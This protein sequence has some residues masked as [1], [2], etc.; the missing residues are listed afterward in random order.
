MS[1]T[2]GKKP[3][4]GANKRGGG[5]CESTFLYPNG[6]CKLHNG[7]AASG[8]AHPQF[9][10]G[11]YAKYLP[12][13]MAEAYQSS[14]N[15]GEGLLD[16]TETLAI[17]DLAV[18][19]AAQRVDEKDTPGFRREAI[20]L[21][22]AAR[23]STDEHDTADLLR[24]LGA[25]LNRG[26]AEDRA[27]GGLASAATSL[28][29][30]AEAAWKVRLSAA[31]AINAAD[32]TGILARVVGIMR[33]EIRDRGVREQVLRRVTSEVMAGRNEPGRP[34]DLPGPDG[35]NGAVED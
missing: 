14:L 24:R 33:E 30:R 6:R 34:G 23:V 15:D 16:L 21:Y 8:I 31:S 26:A 4:C 19:R 9:K 17:L 5:I 7:G 13:R 20:A 3:R 18:K 10:H 1:K 29:K 22:E 25:L 35:G 2:N 27:I 11:R 12:K 28:A 32:L